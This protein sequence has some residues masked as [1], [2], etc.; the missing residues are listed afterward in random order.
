MC[1]NELEPWRA[2]RRKGAGI[3]WRKLGLIFSPDTACEWS[4]SHA[5]LP[6]PMMLEGSL[7]RVYFAARDERNRSHVGYFEIDLDDVTAGVCS[8]S[9][10]PILRPGPL[11]YFDDHGVYTASVVR[12]GSCVFAYT[13]GW[14][15]G[16][17]EPLFYSSIGLAVSNDG[18]STFEKVGRAPIMGRSDYD[19]CLVTSPT[20]LREGNT[21]RMWYVSGYRWEEGEQGPRSKYHIKYAE[22]DDGITWRRDGRVAIDHATPAERNISRA[23][24]MR[25][26]TEY[27]AWYGFDC[28]D[29]YRIGY[30][31]SQDG[32]DWTRC[33]EDAGIDVSL[34]GW[35]CDAIA[36]PAVVE[37]EGRRFMFYNGN[38]FGRDGIGL[39]VAERGS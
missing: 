19:P 36:Y 6:T 14:N 8:V 9:E 15:P 37:W 38:H 26:G 30:A 28:G 3:G 18:G 7:C 11:G 2:K 31:V 35:D 10:G 34:S 17:R 16:P 20:V 29:G 25:T 5:S 22:S 23:W 13:I 33:D 39:A 12:H 1:G 27:Q 21:W 32:L 4:R 24:V